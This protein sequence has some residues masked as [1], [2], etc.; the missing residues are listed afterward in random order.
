MVI[1]KNE[2]RVTKRTRSLPKDKTTN[3]S[4]YVQSKLVIGNKNA[5]KLTKCTKCGMTYSNQSTNDVLTHT[6]FHD[7]HLNGRKWSN[8]W[9]QQVHIA[10]DLSSGSLSTP[11]LSQDD[12]IP[13]NAKIVMIRPNHPSE[14]KATLEIMTMVNN[15]LSAPHDENSFWSQE[16]NPGKAFVYVKDGRA[17]GVITMEVLEKDRGRWMIYKNKSI[18]QNSRPQFILGISRIWVCKSQRLQGIATKLLDASRQNTIFGE[19]VD[20]RFVSWSQPSDNG[21]KMALRYNS[22]KHASG[23]TLIPCYI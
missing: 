12:Y 16:E 18:V 6:S 10:S 8:N 9:G 15:E 5:Y 1:V 4:K 23:E 2:K 7:L 22:V 19:I 11:S 3:K 13:D 20:K 21:G 17:V 14:V